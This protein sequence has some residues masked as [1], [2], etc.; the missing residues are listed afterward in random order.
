MY[1]LGASGYEISVNQINYYNRP[2]YPCQRVITGEKGSIMN[3][4]EALKQNEKAFG[5]MSA[6]LQKA[7]TDLGWKELQLWRS[8]DW[9]YPGDCSICAG[10]FERIDFDL[11]YRLRPDYKEEP[12]IV[13][14]KIHEQM[15]D[16]DFYIDGYDIDG[17]FRPLDHIPD[18]YVFAGF[19]F[20]GRSQVINKA[21]GYA[22][23]DRDI[24][25]FAEIGNI[26]S[27]KDK[28]VTATTVLF[29]KA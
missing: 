29:K 11:T 10:A 28:V 15:V 4:I 25:P 2:N 5:L 17:A 24:L 12:E 16:E 23:N 21:F 7:G 8:N 27:G 9:L 14:C 13:E 6:E 26:K 18:G 3:I 20:E 1:A 22:H 19:R